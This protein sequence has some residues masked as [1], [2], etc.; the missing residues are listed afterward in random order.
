MFS[1]KRAPVRNVRESRVGMGSSSFMTRRDIACGVADCR[2]CEEHLQQQGEGT[3]LIPDVNIILHNMNGLEDP[4]IQNMLFLS[5]V[6]AEVNNRNKGIYARLQRLMA[7]EEKRC[8]AF[9]NDRHEQTCCTVKSGESPREYME[10]CVRVAAQWFARHVDAAWPEQKTSVSV[11]THELSLRSAL[12]NATGVPNLECMSLREYL[13]TIMAEDDELME[14]VQQHSSEEIGE[15][16]A[17]RCRSDGLFPPHLKMPLMEA[18][19][20]SGAYY[21]GKLRVSESNCFFG[22]IRGKF[23]G[24]SFERIFIPGRTNLN[25][26]VHDDIVAV[27]LLPVT[28]WRSR[29]KDARAEDL[30][31]EAEALEKGFQPC[32]RVVGI[33]EQKRRPYCGSIDVSELEKLGPSPTTGSISVLFQPKDNRIPRIRLQTKNVDYLKDKRLSVVMDEWSEF[34]SF[35]D[36]HYIEVL[37]VIGDKDTEAKVILM[38]NDIPHYDF[39]T[40]V[41]DCLPKGQWAVTEEE[42]AVRLDLRDLCVMSVDPLGCRD[43]DDALHCRVIN[44]NHL[45]VGVHIADVTHFLHENTPMDEEAAKRSTSVY[46]VDR[47]INMLPQL[48][49]ENLCSLVEGEDRYAFSIL[50]EFDENLNVVRDW[51][52]KTIIR[53]RAALYYGDA[54][55]MIDDPNDQTEMAKSLRELMRLSKYFKGKREEDGALFLASE[56]FKFKIDNNHV[57]PTD[58]QHYQTFEANSMIEEWMLYANAA[59]ATK[60]YST[61]PRW[62]LLRR[63]QRP[64]EGAFDTLNDALQKRANVLLDDTSSLTLNQSLERC[65][66]LNDPYFNRLI[67]ILTTRCLRQAEYFSSGNVPVE[68]FRHF[69]LAMPLYTHFTSPIRR[70][71]DVIVH[72]QLAAALRIAAVSDTHLNADTMEA[73][74]TNINYR[75]AQAQRAGRDSQNLYTG[76]YLRNFANKAIP[77]EDGYIIRHTD[78]HVAVLVPKYGQESL[79][80]KEDLR[81][82]PALLAK[83]RVRLQLV[84]PHGDVL[85]TKLVYSLPSM[86]KDGAEGAS[87][88]IDDAPAQDA[89]KEDEAAS[90][91]RRFEILRSLVARLSSPVVASRLTRQELCL[92]FSALHKIFS[93]KLYESRELTGLV[94][95][96]HSSV[97]GSRVKRVAQSCSAQEIGMLAEGWSVACYK[98][99]DVVDSLVLALFQNSQPKGTPEKTGP[100][101][102]DVAAV[103]EAAC[104]SQH[105][106]SA[107]LTTFIENTIHTM[108]QLRSHELVASRNRFL[109]ASA[110]YL[111]LKRMQTIH[112]QIQ[113][114][115]EGESSLHLFLCEVVKANQEALQRNLLDRQQTIRAFTADDESSQQLTSSE[116]ARHLL[117]SWWCSYRDGGANEAGAA[118]TL[119]ELAGLFI[120]HGFNDEVLRV[121]LE[122]AIVTLLDSGADTPGLSEVVYKRPQLF[123]RVREKLVSRK[124]ESGSEA[125]QTRQAVQV[126]FHLVLRGQSVDD[127]TLAR[128]AEELDHGNTDARAMAAMTLASSNKLP[129]G[130]VSSLTQEVASLSLKGVGAILFAVQFDFSGAISGLAELAMHHALQSSL[131]GALPEDLSLLS[132]ALS[133][134]LSRFFSPS[135]LFLEEHKKFKEALLQHYVETLHEASVPLLEKVKIAVV[136][137]HLDDEK[138]LAGIVAEQALSVLQRKDHLAADDCLSL[139]EMLTCNDLIHEELLD[140]LVVAVQKDVQKAID[141]PSEDS[142]ALLLRFAS[143]QA[144]LD[145]PGLAAVASTI[146]SAASLRKDAS[147]AVLVAAG[148]L[149]NKDGNDMIVQY[150]L[151]AVAEK[152]DACGPLCAVHLLQLLYDARRSI[153]LPGR[154]LDSLSLILDSSAASVG[155]LD[156]ENLPG[157]IFTPADVARYIV[158][159][160]Q[161][162]QPTAHIGRFEDCEP[163]TTVMVESFP[164]VLNRLSSR[165]ISS[166]I[167]GLGQIPNAGLLLSHQLS[168]DVACDYVV[169]NAELFTSG[170]QIAR[171]LHGF[172]QLHITKRT[173]YAVFSEKLAKRAVL[174]T[175]DRASVSL[176]MSACGTAKYL[177]K[178]LFDK[179]SRLFTDHAKGLTAADL[180]LSIKAMSRVMLLDDAFYETMGNEATEKLAQLS[181]AAQCDLVHAFGA[182]DLPHP[183][184]AERVC[185][186]VASR[187]DELP[188]A[189]SACS[190]LLSLC[191]MGYNVGEDQNLVAVADYITEHMGQLTDQSTAALCAVLDDTNWRH[192]PII[193]ALAEHTIELKKNEQLTPECSRGV[194][195]LLAK[196]FVHHQLARNEL[197][198]LARIVSRDVVSLSEDEALEHQLLVSR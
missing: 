7:D 66:D 111:G 138:T 194:L 109:W 124:P 41:Y 131:R 34:R 113:K 101:L 122:D 98:R 18:G 177:H 146:T 155:T 60:V 151:D 130:L 188:D 183:K 195:D 87:V 63:H 86:M 55:R 74:A 100:K 179:F 10:R 12:E 92:S 43:I 50:W 37:G 118:E 170:K 157:P 73:I 2:T 30:T 65:I 1:K 17:G 40:A 82:V 108:D 110:S 117:Y 6:L 158:V 137:G 186:N 35:P 163:L 84:K 123:P 140:A 182:V 129:D 23:E 172:S 192:T 107:S 44:G 156:N 197:T 85:R 67:R 89:E 102:G 148:L 168:A 154:L 153:E 79:I 196:N 25:R 193:K 57:N 69:G 88:V 76:F 91:K 116:V 95:A 11:V 78:T 5:S 147:P 167:F 39:S 99:S 16:D 184:L 103:V 71:A 187:L 46:L 28:A 31:S 15:A 127:E 191:R 152:S 9:A 173:L 62:T 53:S 132:R 128:V 189:N 47:R 174:A 21:K 165:E 58:M 114:S 29:R 52:G 166:A 125:L 139:I 141:H 64:A 93:P 20:A 51:Y 175:M 134:P 126:A 27:E 145:A 8:Y 97:L 133:Q 54:Q 104:S 150:L 3:V 38:E 77:D 19:V 181:L 48:L 105:Y 180:L 13:R 72:R 198:S 190:V 119:R 136:G 4:R 96:L 94:K 70:Y 42:V 22:E 26:A 45:E 32:G 112:D 143:A 160:A 49:T 56:E 68:E 115:A 80:P 159:Q 169:D 83:V 121:A 178:G 59:A 135:P 24:H 142:E 144:R 75:H 171:M 120:Y 185:A 61:F 33:L 36:G 81:E 14:K 164:L 161:A 162:L 176:T 149:E 90:K 106:S